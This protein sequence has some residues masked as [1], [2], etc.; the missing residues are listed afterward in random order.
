M[1]KY[2]PQ[3]HRGGSN[4][5]IYTEMFKVRQRLFSLKEYLNE[6]NEICKTKCSVDAKEQMDKAYEMLEHYK[7]KLH[8]LEKVSGNFYSL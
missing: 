2:I 1:L 4:M 8:I 6:L 3:K 5:T 7:L